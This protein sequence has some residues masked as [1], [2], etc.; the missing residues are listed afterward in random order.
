MVS[1]NDNEEFAAEPFEGYF[2]ADRRCKY[3]TSSWINNY[4]SSFQWA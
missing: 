1:Y 2:A 3:L 4:Y